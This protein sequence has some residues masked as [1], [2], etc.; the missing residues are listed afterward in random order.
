MLNLERLDVTDKIRFRSDSNWS[1][2]TFG[3][4]WRTKLYSSRV[5]VGLSDLRSHDSWL[6]SNLDI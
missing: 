2:Q 5:P 6:F 3:Q 4:P 1:T